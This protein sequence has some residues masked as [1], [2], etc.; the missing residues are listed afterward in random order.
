MGTVIVPAG[1]DEEVKGTAGGVKGID[2]REEVRG[3]AGGVKTGGDEEMVSVIAGGVDT[4]VTGQVVVV[5]NIVLLKKVREIR[6]RKQFV[7]SLD[8]VDRKHVVKVTGDG[9]TLVTVFVVCG[10]EDVTE[11]VTEDVTEEVT[12][13]VTGHVVLE[14]LTLGNDTDVDDVNERVGKVGAVPLGTVPGRVGV[15]LLVTLPG[16]VGVDLLVTLPGKVGA[17]L[18]VT[19]PGKVGVDLLVTLPGKVGVDLL[20]TLPGRVG[21]VPLGVE[22]LFGG[23]PPWQEV[24][25]MVEVV[26]D[27][28]I[29]VVPF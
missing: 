20:D 16:K 7:R 1:G 24:T 4:L 18:L 22:V 19:L 11:E 15:V 14:K 28:E 17:V 13:E 10:T 5:M 3:M 12:E 9:V 8:G 6:L 25:T 26:R 29:K 21:A 27:V 2:G 23:H